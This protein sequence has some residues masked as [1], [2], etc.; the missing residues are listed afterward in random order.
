MVAMA[1]YGDSDPDS[2][3]S[4]GLLDVDRAVHSRSPGPPHAV[5]KHAYF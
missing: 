2:A 5:A 1:T 4:S 3:L